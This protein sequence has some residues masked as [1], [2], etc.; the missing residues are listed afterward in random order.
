[1]QGIKFTDN[2]IADPD[3]ASACSDATLLVFVLPHQFLGKLC[4]QMTT[5]AD[6]CRCISLIKGIEFDESGPILISNMIKEAMGGMDVSVLMG[7]N[8]ANEVAKDEFC[9]STVGYTNEENGGVWQRLLDCGTFRV[10]SINDVAGVELCGALKNV[11]ALGAGFCDGLGFG[12]NTKAAIIRIGLKE[13]IKFAKMFFDGVKD[14]TFLESC[15]LAD[16]VTTCYGGRN[17]KC[18]EAFAKKEGDWDALEKKMLN[19]Q[20]LQGTI[21]AKDVMVVLREK[22]LVNEFPLFSRIHEIAFEG[23]PAET[24]IE[25]RVPRRRRTAPILPYRSNVACIPL[26]GSCE[27]AEAH[28]GV[29]S[30]PLGH[31]YTPPSLH[32]LPRVRYTSAEYD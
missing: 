28:A 3:L 25:V 16:L 8:V 31:I 21:T 14:D 22:G 18:A 2:V 26:R 19:G 15:G 5:M 27:R 7:A 4:P 6:G 30:K 20:K 32:S 1:V 29:A 24:L 17:R 23:K 13:T 11:V 9:E 10:G 12:G